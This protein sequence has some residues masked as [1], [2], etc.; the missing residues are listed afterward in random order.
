MINSV[1]C[2]LGLDE[3]ELT[4]KSQRRSRSCPDTRSGG[5]RAPAG[6][7]LPAPLLNAGRQTQVHPLLRC[8]LGPGGRAL[9]LVGK[10]PEDVP[11]AALRFLLAVAFWGASLE[12]SRT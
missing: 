3:E 7:L 2:E 8:G 1:L 6:A 11:A 10:R 9:P 12:G 5:Q 4:I